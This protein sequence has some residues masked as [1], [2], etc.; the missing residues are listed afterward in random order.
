MAKSKKYYSLKNIKAK[1]A[2]Y[3]VIFGERS[4]GKTYAV[5]AEEILEN[6]VKSDGVEQGAIIRRFDDDFIGVTSARSMFNSLVFN[7]N[8]QNIIKEKTKIYD[9]V[10][11]YGGAYYMCVKDEKTGKLLRTS[12]VLAYAFALTS[13]QSYKSGS[14]PHITTILF[15]EFMTRSFYLRDEF[16]TFQGILSTIIRDRDNVKI[17]MCANTVNK[18]GCPYFAE[19]GLTHVKQMKQGDIDVYEYGETGLRVA[20]EW[21]DSPSK[22]G[23]ASDV[24]FA[25]NNPRLKMITNGVWEMAIYPHCPAK[26]KPKD[27]A[28]VYFIHYDDELLQC[29]IVVSETDHFTFVHRK[30]GEIKNDDDITFDLEPSSKPNRRTRI[31]APYDNIGKR[32]YSYYVADKVFYQDNEVGEIVRNYLN[33]CR[34]LA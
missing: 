26:Y 1:N 4:N 18:Y 16:I 14:Y 24:Y 31:S 9:G 13:E 27:V 33:A 17:Y 7:G 32:I 21:A 8:G 19:M 29:E 12:V 2:Q 22:T 20:V 23:K 6:F 3:A 15:D 28:L 25:F 34:K 10:E 5:C 11:Y 30:T